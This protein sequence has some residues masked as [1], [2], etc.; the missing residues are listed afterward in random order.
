MTTSTIPIYRQ[1][2]LRMRS[3]VALDLPPTDEPDFDVDVRWG[4]DTVESSVRPPGAVVACYETDPDDW[5]YVA[6]QSDAGYRIRFS[7]CG[8]FL[9]SLDLRSIEVRADRSGR[10]ELLPILLAG[11]VS[12]LL[13][14]LRGTTVLHAS[15]VAVEDR[16]L[17]FIG[18][19]GRGKSTMATLMCLGGGELIT[20][21]VL[22]VD[23]GPPV[24]CVGGA[25]ELRL[26]EAAAGLADRAPEHARRL[27]ADERRAF[28][29]RTAAPGSHPLS[30]V[31]VPSPS[32]DADRLEI[33]HLSVEN[34]L[35]ALMSFPRVHGVERPDL[36]AAQFAAVAAI[37]NQ[38]PVYHAI[39]PWGPPFSDEL[40][41][42][43]AALARR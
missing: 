9:V 32:R 33:R 3:E 2:G 15:A 19:S 5:W 27:T 35:M 38:I 39:V 41:P 10:P 8:E 22:A 26:R 36:V 23:P 20:D 34:A 25:S 18:Q 21:D 14:R 16:A 6:T 37:A 13:L 12:A 1:C 24:T 29:P 17:A 7:G 30:A 11:T 4:P 42:A 31:I 28:S 43:L 40:A